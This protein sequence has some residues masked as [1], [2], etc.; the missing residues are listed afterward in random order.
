MKKYVAEAFGTFILVFFG[1]GAAIFVGL[2][3]AGHLG[4]AFAFGLALIAAAYGIGGISGCHI[5]PAVSAGMF[6]AGRMEKEDLI[7][8]VIGQVVGALV[9]GFL[10]LIVVNGKL[11]GYD[12]GLGQNGWGAGY[13][14]E[15]GFFSAVIFEFIATLI[16]V[17]VILG[18]TEDA[19]M[20]TIAGLIIG[21]TL[22]AIHITGI[23]ITG[24]SVN[25][26]R[27]FGP[28]LWA[29]P[30][31][32]LALP[33]FLI[34]PTLGGIVAGILF[35]SG[36]LSSKDDDGAGE[37][38]LSNLFDRAKEMTGKVTGSAKSTA[39]DAKDTAEDV[40]DGTKSTMKTK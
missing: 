16:F 12:G 20:S 29:G 31:A 26:A 11:G 8:Y 39:N 33:V 32:W 4:I 34:V 37:E 25:P 18:V 10:L 7:G 28:A 6:F 40:V 27:S 24:V 2:D 38:T 23:Q 1:C 15:Y 3:S 22:V 21:L 30:S 13:L 5:N 9:A 35:K 36:I 14:G 19:K 17:A